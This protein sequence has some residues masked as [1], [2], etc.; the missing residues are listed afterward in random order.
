MLWS[1]EDRALANEWSTQVE[2]GE[3]RRKIVVIIQGI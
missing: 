3:H 1:L 2:K